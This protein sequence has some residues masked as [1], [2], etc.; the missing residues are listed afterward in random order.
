[1]RIKYPRTRHLPWSPGFTPDD[2]VADSV[3]CFEGK[4]V[5]VTEKMDGENTT[6][7][8][9]G[10]HAR[11]LSSSRHPSRSWVAQLQAQIGHEIPS[12]WRIC[13]ENL[14]A[15][16]SLAYTNL[17]GYFYVFSIWNEHN[18]C[19]SWDDTQEWAELLGL[20]VVP[21]IYRGPWD[22]KLVKSIQIDEV[23][24]EGYVVRS[25]EAFHY[26]EFHANLAKWVRKNHV[27]TEDHWMQKAVVPNKLA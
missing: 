26:N 12:G 17:K 20:P 6:I 5:V 1:M 10:L 9:D 16:H 27:Q 22:E 8:Q 11:S 14:Y 24:Q 18:T 15:Q 4:D 19:L 7:Y 23:E 3:D 25:T 21:Q 13:G 2:L